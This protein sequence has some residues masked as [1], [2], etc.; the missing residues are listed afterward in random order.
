VSLSELSRREQ[1]RQARH[2]RILDA[3]L[4]VFSVNGYSATTMDMIASESGLSKPTLYQYFSSKEI[5][6]GAMM[7]A[8]RDD[9]LLVFEQSASLDMVEQLFR[10]A[11]SYADTVMR[12]EFLSLARLIIGEAQRFPEIGRA[13]Q[14]SGPDR[15]LAGLIVYL[16]QQREA[17]RLE[18]VEGELAAQDFWGLILSAPRNRALHDPEAVVS[19]DDIARYLHNGLTVFLRAY[20][21]DANADVARLQQLIDLGAWK[22]PCNQ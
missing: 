1:N 16:L 18:V 15:V 10:F 21:C 7:H 20:S 4:E 13:Y 12:S 5:L 19:R 9:M 17:G 11:W 14:A 6:F 2:R 8:R 22:S 3:A